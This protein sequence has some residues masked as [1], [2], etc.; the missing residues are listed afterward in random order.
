MM[1]NNVCVVMTLY[2]I[3]CVIIQQLYIIIILYNSV[4][5]IITCNNDISMGRFKMEI[6]EFCRK[7]DKCCCNCWEALKTNDIFRQA[8]TYRHYIFIYILFYFIIWWFEACD[9]LKKTFIFIKLWGMKVNMSLRFFKCKEGFDMKHAQ[10]D[11]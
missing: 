8:L 3:T 5:T 10:S 1:H 6:I 11:S 7:T 4:C 2:N 9:W